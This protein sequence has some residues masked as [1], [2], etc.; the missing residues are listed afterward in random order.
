MPKKNC[1]CNGIKRRNSQRT[2]V[3]RLGF[4]KVT[5]GAKLWER[6]H[7]PL[8][9]SPPTDC[10]QGSAHHTPGPSTSQGGSMPFVGA[11]SKRPSPLPPPWGT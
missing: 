5:E 8:N 4:L 7:G 2:L 11:Q 1:R 6:L 10:P 3:Q 9:S